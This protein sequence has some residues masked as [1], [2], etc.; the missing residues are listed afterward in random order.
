MHLKTTTADD[1]LATL[2]ELFPRCFVA[3]H[4]EPHRALKVGIR[5]DLVGILTEAEIDQALRWYCSRLMY[6]RAIA[7][8][9]TR[10]GLDGEPAGEITA[11][12]VEHARRSVA[13]IEIERAKRAV[14]RKAEKAITVRA[15]PDKPPAAAPKRDGLSGLRAAALARR[16]GALVG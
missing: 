8:G 4:Y 9:G 10:T 7:A 6:H 2:A 15:L 12:E 16:T 13:R 3:R 11:D 5:Q 1:V 14:A